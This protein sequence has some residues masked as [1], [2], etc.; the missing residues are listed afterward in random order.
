MRI[1][2]EDG[3]YNLSPMASH[4]FRMAKRTTSLP[5]NVTSSLS[6]GATRFVDVHQ[7]VL[8]ISTGVLRP[9]ESAVVIVKSL[10]TITLSIPVLFSLPPVGPVAFAVDVAALVRLGLIARRIVVD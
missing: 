9:D 5:D 2:I 1:E 7:S 8:R 10:G 4:F 3:K 6:C